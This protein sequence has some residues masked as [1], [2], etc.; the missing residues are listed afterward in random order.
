MWDD[1]TPL[2]YQRW[3][4]SGADSFGGDE[5]CAGFWEG[6]GDGSWDDMYGEASCSQ[7]LPYLC[8]IGGS[9]KDRQGQCKNVAKS[10]ATGAGAIAVIVVCIVVGLLA[11]LRGK[12]AAARL[13]LRAQRARALPWA[14]VWKTLGG[15]AADD[16]DVEDAAKDEESVTVTLWR[17]GAARRHLA[18]QRRQPAA[19]RCIRV[20]HVQ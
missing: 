7:P 4:E 6:R 11:L 10:R 12:G 18:L 14:A 8:G 20:M 13:L 2:D 17:E 3:S 19:L 5:D 9:R 1:G 15:R 16:R